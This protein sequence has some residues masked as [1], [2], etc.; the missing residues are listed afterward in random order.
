MMN[1]K[2]KYTTI[3]KYLY[4]SIINIFQTPLFNIETQFYKTGFILDYLG[5]A[6][7]TTNSFR[8]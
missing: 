2:N 5:A 1:N 7:K 3:N 6:N 4:T 8:I